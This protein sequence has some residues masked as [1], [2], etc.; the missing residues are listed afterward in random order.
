MK[1]SIIVSVEGNIGS[2]KSTL[3]RYLQEKYIDDYI[4]NG[5]MR[6]TGTDKT[7]APTPMSNVVFLQEPVDVWSRICDDKGVTILEHFYQDQEKYAFAFQMMAYISRLNLLKSTIE[8]YP[9]AI[10]VTERSLYTDKHVFMRMLN[11]GKQIN[12]IERAIYEE[13]FDSFSDG[14][15]LDGVIYVSADPEKCKERVEHRSRD[16]ESTISLDYLRTC[17][18]YHEDMLKKENR[19]TYMKSPSNPGSML[20][21]N[22]NQNFDEVCD[23]W[24]REVFAYIYATA[25]EAHDGKVELSATK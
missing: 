13:W 4:K 9:D 25:R 22:G 14:F 7:D 16:G 24:C 8:K 11:N 17:H 2:G 6:D 21:L 10:I 1:K 19:Q 20:T 3:T 15:K 23:S 12:S 5:G 18:D